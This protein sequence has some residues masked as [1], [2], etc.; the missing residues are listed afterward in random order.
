[1]AH[2][3]ELI[4]TFIHVTIHH[5]T[6]DRFLSSFQTPIIYSLEAIRIFNGQSGGGKVDSAHGRASMRRADTEWA[7]MYIFMCVCVCV[8]VCVI[9]R[10]VIANLEKVWSV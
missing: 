6:Y 3:I 2:L 5:K 10:Y 1:M 4:C 7:F 8:C 9:M